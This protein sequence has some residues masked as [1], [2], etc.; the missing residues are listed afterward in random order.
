MALETPLFVED[1]EYHASDFRRYV[2]AVSGRTPG[3]FRTGDLKV[4]Q[5]GS[6]ANKSIDVA[7][8]EVLIDGD[9]L[10]NQGYYY[11]ASDAVTNITV[12]DTAS[13]PRKDLVVAYIR[14][15]EYSGTINSDSDWIDI[16]VGTPASSPV[17]PATPAN[18]IVLAEL[19]VAASFSSVTN[20]NIT[21]RRIMN[22]H[23]SR[24]RG[25]LLSKTFGLNTS[26]YGATPLELLGSD[27]TIPTLAGRVYRYAATVRVQ[28]TQANQ[29][30]NL[31]VYRGST[32]I[33]APL[34]VPITLA[35]NTYGWYLEVTDT[36]GASGGTRYA[37][38]AEVVVGT[39]TGS[40]SSTSVCSLDDVGGY[41]T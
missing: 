40:S 18:S 34:S 26:P 33:G 32:A 10:T 21:D 30:H 11:G 1:L 12:P 29:I 7:A 41:P 36:P 37:V 13:N 20:A 35:A 16:V 2:R 8:G 31:Q 24:P 17:V 19:S 15:A 23:E 27:I 6:G 5:R 14:D 22:G 38:R 28:A 9:E 3:I 25:V 4:S 39:G